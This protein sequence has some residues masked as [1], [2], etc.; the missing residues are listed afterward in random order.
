MW[1]E[2]LDIEC[3]HTCNQLW[4]DQ[5]TV[6]VKCPTDGL[7]LEDK[8]NVESTNHMKHRGAPNDVLSVSFSSQ[9]QVVVSKGH[10]T[11]DVWS[12]HPP[13]HLPELY[14]HCVGETWHTAQQHGNTQAK[15]F[16]NQQTFASFCF[17]ILVRKCRTPT[18]RL[19]TCHFPLKLFSSP[20]PIYFILRC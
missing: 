16:I 4:G 18:D 11:Q 8:W 1:C 6:F 19:N 17:S 9:I 7:L 5:W 3:I 13:L 2:Q 14:H 10:R 12:H 15:T 20:R